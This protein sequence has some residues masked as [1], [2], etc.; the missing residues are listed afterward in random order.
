M[1]YLDPA[2]PWADAVDADPTAQVVEAALA[3]RVTMRF[4]DRA[5]GLDTVQEWEAVWFPLSETVDPGAAIDVD[6][7]DRDLRSAA[8]DGVTY[9]LPDAPVDRPAYF[10]D[11][12]RALTRHLLASRSVEVH[13]NRQL[14]LWSRVGEDRDDFA[15]RCDAAAQQRADA[16]TAALAKRMRTRQAS[17]DKALQ[18]AQQRLEQ[19]DVDLSSRRSQELIAGA[20]SVLSAG[21]VGW[22]RRAPSRGVPVGCC[23]ARRVGE[24]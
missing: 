2:A 17:L 10:R 8:P 11:A 15:A 21:S 22:A 7:D 3:A 14:D 9:R 19:L 24:R 4:D 12:E 13:V 18:T 16:D 5:S 23:A 1:R 20:G 6:H